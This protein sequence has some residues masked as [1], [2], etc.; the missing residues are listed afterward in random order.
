MPMQVRET[1][2][3]SAS[4]PTVARAPAKAQ[5]AKPAPAPAAD[6][7]PGGELEALVAQWP[8]LIERIGKQALTAKTV[9]LDARPAQVRG[10]RVA[11]GFD[12][13][14]AA[15]RERAQEPRVAKAVQHVVGQVLGRAVTVEFVLLQA[16]GPVVL[17][18]DH[19]PEARKPAAG[20]GAGPAAAKGGRRNWVEE[21]A[22]RKALETFN[23]S[24][25]DV[26]D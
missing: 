6:A 12:P 14:F 3:P 26:R 10:D 8:E 18:T 16:D 25:V 22:V 5:P 19:K 21:P 2:V 11:I 1:A 24:I 9:L 17:P 20:G 4:P 7:K 13:E 23:G 15:E